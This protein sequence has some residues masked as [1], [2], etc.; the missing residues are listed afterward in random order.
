MVAQIDQT[1]I[2]TRPS[3]LWPRLLAYALFE[4]RP[5]TTRARWINPFIRAEFAL[6]RRL[7]TMQ[8]CPAPVFIIGTGR[9]GTTILG[10]VLSMHRDVGFLNEPKLL[11]HTVI[12]SED[13]IGSYGRGAARYRLAAADATAEARL[14]VERIYGAY[15]R[16]GRS[17]RLVDKYPEMMFRVPFLRALFPDAR[18]LFLSRDGWDTCSSVGQWSSQH[19]TRV[20]GETHDWWGADQR[21]WQLLVAQ[22]IPGHPDLAPH[23]AALR[24]LSDH[25]AMAAVEWIVTMREGLQQMHAHAD[26]VM[27]V[28]YEGL[29]QRPVETVRRIEAFLGLPADP[30]FESYAAATLAPARPR[31]RFALPAFLIE[32]FDA[33]QAALRQAQGAP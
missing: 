24:D 21:K 1:Y 25:Q 12:G 16:L 4:G 22:I 27:H 14:A 33:T 18:F 9:S 10:I 26:A 5:L 30:V 6:F 11:W 3:K 31:A 29:C 8:A 17:R 20:K 2:R 15:L 32:P 7:P 28:P 13:L 19:G 23:A